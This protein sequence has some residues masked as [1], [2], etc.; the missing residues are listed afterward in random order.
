MK[1]ICNPHDNIIRISVVNLHHNLNK[2]AMKNILNYLI[3]LPLLALNACGQST[4]S[5]ELTSKLTAMENTISKPGN[6]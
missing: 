4:K 2:I 3:I 1:P 6:P 5:T